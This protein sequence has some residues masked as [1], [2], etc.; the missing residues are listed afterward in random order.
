MTSHTPSHSKTTPTMVSRLWAGAAILG[1]LLVLVLVGIRLVQK[2]NNP[3]ALGQA[4]RDF[5]LTTFSGDVIDTTELR[6]KVV[7]INF[8]ASWCS[9]CDQEALLLQE[10]WQK[11]KPVESDEILFLGVAY[12]DTQP[13]SLDFL[14]TYGVTFPN[15]QDLRG[16]ISKV[17]QVKSVPET[18]IL[19]QE[20]KLQY[21]KIGPFSSLSEITA[22]IDS[23]LRQSQP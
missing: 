17:Y 23:V 1:V 15:G 3:V 20:G 6:G 18:F 19:D 4:P 5:T 21:F 7:L 16:E 13:A 14:S 8:W 2:D 22:A 9:T 11:Y 10:A 12:M